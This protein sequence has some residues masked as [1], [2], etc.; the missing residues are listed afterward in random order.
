M[1]AS[2]GEEVGVAQLMDTYKITFIMTLPD[3]E[4]DLY[5]INFHIFGL[6]VNTYKQED[7]KVLH[8]C[9]TILHKHQQ[10]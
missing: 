8:H 10:Y 3:M 9:W 1:C 5:I 6:E 4:L 7:I 2:V